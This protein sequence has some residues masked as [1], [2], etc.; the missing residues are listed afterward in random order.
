MRRRTKIVC[1]L[2]PASSDA[3]TIRALVQ[4]GMDVARLNLSHGTHDFHSQLIERVREAAVGEHKTV[5]ILLD[6][7]GPK[8][9]VGDVRGGR[10]ILEKGE[11]PE[12]DKGST[13]DYEILRLSLGVPDGSH[14]IEVD[15][16]PI[17][18][19][20][21]EALNGVSFEKGCYVGQEVT[22]RMQ[23]RG[24]VRKKLYGV[25]VEGGPGRHDNCRAPCGDRVS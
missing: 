17:L 21:F 18:E 5:P 8:I 6:L 10:V 3:A 4:A 23:Y 20:N 12:G 14:D 11:V 13:D 24:A 22:A 7:Q 19:A 15:K 16:R 9:R 25:T 2:G 1:T